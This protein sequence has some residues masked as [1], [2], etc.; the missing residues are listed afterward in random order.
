MNRTEHYSPGLSN[1]K[2]LGLDLYLGESWAVLW[3]MIFSLLWVV[4]DFSGTIAFARVKHRTWILEALYKCMI[5]S[6]ISSLYLIFYQ[7]LPCKIFLE[8]A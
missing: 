5:F 2:N 3:G 6:P 8:S 1:H 7:F 4:C